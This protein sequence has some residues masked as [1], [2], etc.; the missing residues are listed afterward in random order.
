MLGHTLLLI[1]IILAVL[2][3][4]SSPDAVKDPQIVAITPQDETYVEIAS[5]F[6]VD[7]Q[8]IQK[9]ATVIQENAIRPHTGLVL[10]SSTGE[11]VHELTTRGMYTTGLDE[12]KYMVRYAKETYQD[13]HLQ[14]TYTS[15]LLYQEH[16]LTHV[17]CF[18]Y[19]FGFIR[20]KVAVF[21][22]VHQWLE[23][24]G[25]FFI[26]VPK[27][28]NPIHTPKYTAIKI[29]TT[30]REKA[31]LDK[32]Y[33]INREVYWDSEEKLIRLASQHGFEHYRTVSVPY[34]VRIF[35]SVDPVYL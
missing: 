18:N 2:I 19:T 13:T 23:L 22:C 24:G 30:L 5:T 34:T 25:L 4:F 15:P 11:L 17:I 3:I 26:H 12:S 32:T 20:D 1:F 33:T 7:P 14:G 31:T 10:G 16:S 35:R 6:L 9:E 8:R 28:W 27:Q 29:N 21:R